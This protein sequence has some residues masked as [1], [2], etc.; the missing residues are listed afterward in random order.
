MCV[1]RV[2]GDNCNTGKWRV[3]DENGKPTEVA[4]NDAPSSSCSG[5]HGRSTGWR[6]YVEHAKI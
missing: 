3:A 5:P 4:E 6:C 2:G 1:C